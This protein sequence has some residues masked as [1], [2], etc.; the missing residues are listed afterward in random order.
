M[1]RI[2]IEDLPE[3]AEIGKEDLRRIRG[4]NLYPY[5]SV[6]LDGKGD[7]R[8]VLTARPFI[9]RIEYIGKVSGPTLK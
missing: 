4:G 8:P 9:S 7:D 1:A 2:R 6:A 3:N 5:F